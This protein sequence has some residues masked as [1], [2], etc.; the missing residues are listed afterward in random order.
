MTQL[1]SQILGGHHRPSL[2]VGLF[3]GAFFTFAAMKTY[4]WLEWTRDMVIGRPAGA[5]RKIEKKQ[6]EIQELQHEAGEARR[7]GCRGGV[8]MLIYAL[9]AA[10]LGWCIVVAWQTGIP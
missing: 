6:E 9:L 10:G 5:R 2:F 8:R 1:L 3:L 4:G 7:M